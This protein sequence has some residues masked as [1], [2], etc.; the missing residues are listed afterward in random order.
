[1]CTD[2]CSRITSSMFP[3]EEAS[4]EV[5]RQVEVARPLGAARLVPARYVTES[6]RVLLLRARD[7]GFAELDLGARHALAKLL[8]ETQAELE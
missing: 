3:F 2:K 4:G 8:L 5:V 1:M 6:A 7:A